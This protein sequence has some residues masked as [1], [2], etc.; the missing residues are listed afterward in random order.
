MNRPIIVT[1]GPEKA[2]HILSERV[3]V[4]LSAPIRW[5]R[6]QSPQIPLLDKRER[7][8]QRGR[9]EEGGKRGRREREEGDKWK[10]IRKWF[11]GAFRR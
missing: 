1:K 2:L 3:K 11:S 9:W 10:G 7:E 4:H 5:S 6:L 8:G